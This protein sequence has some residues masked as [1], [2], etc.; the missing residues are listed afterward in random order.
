MRAGQTHSAQ[1]GV[2][3][4]LHGNALVCVCMVPMHGD[5]RVLATHE[6]RARSRAPASPL[7]V[8]SVRI[9]Q[10]AKSWQFW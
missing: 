6:R 9:P 1:C 8:V 10:T 2:L 4:V 7:G 3:P 5:V